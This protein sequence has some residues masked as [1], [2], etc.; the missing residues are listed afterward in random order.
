MKTRY[1]L[2]LAAVVGAVV[3]PGAAV[4]AP[5]EG[6]LRLTTVSV[7]EGF[8]QSRNTFTF[9]ELVY[10]GGKLVGSDHAVCKF[11]GQ[12]ENIRCRIT[13]WL[14]HGKLF[15]FVRITPDP[16]GSFRVTGGTG[17]YAGKTGVGI[18]RN[19]SDTSSKV[20]I[21]LTS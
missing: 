17:K 20:T 4:A 7:D 19:V 2:A 11:R 3:V 9:S 18:F 1:A 16:Q 5:P 21:W 8:S 13:V 6:S 12:F 15:L 14:P 10:Q